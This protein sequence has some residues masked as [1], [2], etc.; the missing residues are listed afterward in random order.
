[1]LALAQRRPAVEACRD[2]EYILAGPDA[3][4]QRLP[5]DALDVVDRAL[6]AAAADVLSG[7]TARREVALLAKRALNWLP[8]AVSAGLL[9]GCG[10]VH[11][12]RV[13]ADWGILEADLSEPARKRS[14]RPFQD[15]RELEYV[16]AGPDSS[17][18]YFP[19]GPDA[20]EIVDLA[21]R[22]ATDDVVAGRKTQLD[23]L[24]LVSRAL[25]W[26]PRARSAGLLVDCTAA[27]LEL[28]EEEWCIMETDLGDTRVPETEEAAR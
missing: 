4:P 6:R 16:L 17:P 26:L 15:F 25:D 23:A 20:V 10:T 2:L 5:P 18:R 19:L 22:A 8:R 7:R 28:L 1:M 21:L 11:L 14:R 3:S 27:D 12:A 9:S 13:E 24:Q